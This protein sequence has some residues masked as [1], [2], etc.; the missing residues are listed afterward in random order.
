MKAKMIFHVST[1]FD[2]I[3]KPV[4]LDNFRAKYD[5]PYPYH[6]TLKN[7]TYFDKND[8]KKLK[9][10]LGKITKE[11]KK[12]KITFDKLFI[13][14]SPK[15]ICIM[16]KAQQNKTLL[17]LQKEISKQLSKYGKHTHKAYAKFEKN[18]K[19]HITIAR[20]L[21]PKQLKIAKSELEKNLR[22]QAI[23]TNFTLTTVQHDLFKEWNNPKNKLYYKLQNK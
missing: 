17:K 20:Y 22:C 18:F 15:G 1:D 8:F 16:I 13:S 23:I 2:L 3:Q 21:N 6:I 5:K 9:N 14:P 4:W 10:D 7:S 12:I 19:P 11:Y